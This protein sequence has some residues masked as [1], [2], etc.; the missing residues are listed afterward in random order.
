MADGEGK[1]DDDSSFYDEFE[2]Q[3]KGENFK[4]ESEG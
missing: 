2:R 4:G 1:G 3:T